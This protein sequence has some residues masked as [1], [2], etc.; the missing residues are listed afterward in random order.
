[1][2]VDIQDLIGS[3]GIKEPVYPGKKLVRKYPIS[4]D[5]KSH[6]VVFD[7]HDSDLF[8]V[9]L[10]AGLSGKTL[11]PADL[12]AY[13]VSY[14]ARTY[15]DIAIRE[16]EDED[17][18]EEGSK[19]KSGGGGKKPAAKKP[20]EQEVSLSAFDKV[21]E[22]K[23]PETG[24]IEKFVVMGKELAKEAFSTAFENLKQQLGQAK[25]MAMDIMKGVANIVKATPGGGLEARGDES[26]T[27]KYDAEKTAGMFGGMAPS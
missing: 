16:G 23:I 24:T 27:Y 26:V 17:E 12:H 7:W 13:P 4:G 1:M 5:H 14:Q 8:H 25:V 10:K 3:A 9:E 21:T 2:K 20:E 18:G 15:L 6:C 22:G 11:D 19:G